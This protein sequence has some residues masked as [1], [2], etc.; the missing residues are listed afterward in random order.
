MTEKAFV[1]LD[2]AT[3]IGIIVVSLLFAVA[4][5]GFTAS[6]AEQ[7][8]CARILDALH[9]SNQAQAAAIA[10]AAGGCPKGEKR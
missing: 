8:V 4:V 6:S 2:A 7:Q 9:A 5:I 3:V 1:T 10:Q